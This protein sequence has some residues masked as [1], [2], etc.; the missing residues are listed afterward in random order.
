M[1]TLTPSLVVTAALAGILA[2]AVPARADHHEGKKGE[3]KGKK[4]KKAKGEP[5]MAA[6]EDKVHCM[7]V[8][9][10][11]GKSECAVEGKSGCAGHNA[12]KGQG[13]VTL[14]KKDCAEQKGTVVGEKAPEKMGMPANEKG[15]EKSAEK[16]AAPAKKK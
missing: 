10:C 4:D 11:K 9:A 6:S 8:N 15:A 13:W 1:K 5:K 14:A 3:H 2:A 12:C 7:G 16:A